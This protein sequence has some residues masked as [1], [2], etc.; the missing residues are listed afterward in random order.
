MVAV[1]L[2]MS[3]VFCMV[4]FWPRIAAKARWRLARRAGRSGA[5]LG[6]WSVLFGGA[7]LLVAVD[8]AARLVVSCPV[9]R[10]AIGFYAVGALFFKRD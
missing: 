6:V 8:C 7:L 4:V 10:V 3:C 9:L 5:A 1:S 2:V